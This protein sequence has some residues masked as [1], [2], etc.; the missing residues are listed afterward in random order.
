[1][2]ITWYVFYTHTHTHKAKEEETREI[3]KHTIHNA[4]GANWEYIAMKFQ[5]C[6]LKLYFH[7]RIN[8][9]QGNETKWAEHLACSMW[10]SVHSACHCACV[11]YDFQ[12]T[13]YTISKC[14]C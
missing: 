10:T 7:L 9:K 13:R 8:K 4:E 6:I 11:T 3:R 12:W 5:L 14:L 2:A 1:M